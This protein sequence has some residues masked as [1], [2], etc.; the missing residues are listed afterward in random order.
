MRHGRDFAKTQRVV[1]L[2]DE[3]GRPYLQ[4]AE[5]EGVLTVTIQLPDFFQQ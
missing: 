1:P 4:H 2:L 3:I 5:P